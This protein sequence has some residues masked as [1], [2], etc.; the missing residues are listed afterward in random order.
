MT[1]PHLRQ[2]PF[3][4]RLPAPVFFRLESMPA[5]GMYPQLRHAWGE[6]VYSYS[7]VTELRTEDK[8]LLAPPHMGFWIPEGALQLGFNRRAVVHI[9]VYIS[10]DLCGDMPDHT[11]SLI[12]TP[13]LR[14]MLDSL[15]GQVFD[16]SERQSRFLRVLVDEL[17]NCTVTD[18]F[19]PDSGDRQLAR[20]LD[21]LRDNPA[22]PRSNAD[23]A[24]AYGLS[25]RTLLRRC[26]RDLGMSLTEWR[27]R[28]RVV[29][30]ISLLQQ[31]Q[32]VES[33][34]LDLGYGTASAFIAM[35]RRIT[36]STPGRF[37]GR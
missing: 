33:V 15:K 6:F 16:G 25:E 27:Q 13:L 23:L 8:H 19:V 9:S 32:T 35:F 10:T 17:A 5:N 1:A 12:V 22:D 21:A 36:G 31:G 30:A 20:I 37:V 3:R 2:P 7:G 18:S 14:A 34:A 4:D 24:K 28:E 29:H 26:E 11:C